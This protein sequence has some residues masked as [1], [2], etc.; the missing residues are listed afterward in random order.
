MKKVLI[1]LMLLVLVGCG[2]TDNENLVEYNSETVKSL[3][4]ADM[5]GY[6][7]YESEFD[8]Y[9]REGSFALANSLLADD[10]TY[11]LYFGF[12][13]CPFCQDAIPVIS[14]SAKKYGVPVIYTDP[15]NNA[16]IEAYELFV[17]NYAEVLELVEGERKLYT[18]LLV[19][20]K[21]GEIVYHH[22]GTVEGHNPSQASLNDEQMELLSGYFSEGFN[23]LLSE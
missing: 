15:Y 5:S 6:K 11:V 17:E 4:V 3:A 8:G 18:P 20:V 10:E 14:A 16:S 1:C 2:S 21:N 7:F 9:F 22:L 23:K 19:F 12:T 13:G